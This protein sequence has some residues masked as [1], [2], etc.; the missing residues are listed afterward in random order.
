MDIMFKCCKCSIKLDADNFNVN[1]NWGSHE[2]LC[3]STLHRNLFF[4]FHILYDITWR[5]KNILNNLSKTYLNFVSCNIYI[6]ISGEKNAVK[7][8]THLQI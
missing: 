8:T 6:I 5:K 3:V 7:Q 2:I 1:L 4:W